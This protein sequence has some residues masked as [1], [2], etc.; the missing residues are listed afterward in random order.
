MPK[1]W[2]RVYSRCSHCQSQL[3]VSAEQLRQSRGLLKCS[4]C[5]KRFDALTSLS[6]QAET[7]I[8]ERNQVDIFENS[9]GRRPHFFGWG[10][11]SALL[12]LTLLAQLV[13]FE[14]DWLT[15]QPNL[16]AGWQ[17]FCDKLHCRLPDYQII[18]EW[19]LSHSDFRQVASRRYE[20]SAAL[21]N[22]AEFS[23]R[24]PDLKLV[25]RDLRG[26]AVAERIFSGWQYTVTDTLPADETAEIRLTVVAPPGVDEIGGY[27]FALI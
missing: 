16:R 25:L 5:G 20:F 26:Q 22:Q 18:A 17:A 1:R 12:G 24:F 13:Y 14:G 21:T 19:T 27:S 11:G 15:R 7:V 6:E 3:Q 8:H 10:L 4:N 23:Q 9:G 2:F